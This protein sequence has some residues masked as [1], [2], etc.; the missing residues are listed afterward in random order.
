MAVINGTNSAET[1]Y[2]T[3]A[4]DTI[5]GLGGNDTIWADSGNDT[6]YGGAGNDKVYG[7]DGNDTL[8]GEANNDQL[9]GG[10][11]DDYLYGGDNTDY[12]SGDI[13]NDYLDGGAGTDAVRYET[14]SSGVVVNLALGTASDGDGGT[15]TIVNIEGVVGSAYSDTIIGNS[16][17]G[18][19]NG[20]LGAD[21]IYAGAGHDN[22]WGGHSINDVSDDQLYGEAGND[23]FIADAGNDLLDGGADIDTVNFSD[24]ATGIIVNL[25]TG[26][27]SDGLGGTD[28]LVSIENILGSSYGDTVIGDSND[29]YIRL[30]LGDD[31]VYGGDG[32]DQLEGGA[33][34]DTFVFETVSAFN[35][36]D[37][38]DDFSVVDNDK[39]DL[40]DLLSA[41]D[42]LT[43]LI[44]DFIEVT[45]S[46]AN[47][48]LKVDLDGTGTTY[49]MAQIVE[50]RNVTGLTDEAALV[51]SGN[52]IV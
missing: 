33:G 4:A 12:L 49:S 24:T 10:N 50:L 37:L 41:Y 43:D 48:V 51:T 40:S 52:I 31:I 21:Y 29:N 30:Y 8:Y 47:S 20:G 38:I 44:T 9:W 2:G 39:I 25:A 15:D 6:V 7:Q 34:S 32:L 19:F 1:L 18:N 28:T 11:G 13:G 46:G 27:A 26:T 16:A 17:S 42:P 5:S 22:I 23:Q 3:S 45:T 35:D 14:A 36:I